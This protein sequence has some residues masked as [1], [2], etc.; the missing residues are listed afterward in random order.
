MVLNFEKLGFYLNLNYV[1][2]NPDIKKPKQIKMT[3][4]SQ[5][6]RESFKVSGDEILAPMFAAIGVIAAMA[7]DCTIIVEK[8]DAGA[9]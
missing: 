8:R 6:N 7:T 5:S 3:D 2:V 4:N 1:L 9:K